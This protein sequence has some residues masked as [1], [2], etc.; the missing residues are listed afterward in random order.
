[1]FRTFT[2]SLQSDLAQRTAA[3]QAPT[4]ASGPSRL[5]LLWS[6]NDGRPM[7]SWQREPRDRAED[8]R[9]SPD[10]VAA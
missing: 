4:A 3:P 2:A 1:M 6:M 10:R 7:A 5:R 8:G 9:R